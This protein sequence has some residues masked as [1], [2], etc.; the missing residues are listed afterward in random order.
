MDGL[1]SIFGGLGS[2]FNFILNPFILIFVNLLIACYFVFATLNVPSPLG[3]AVIAV[4]IIIRVATYPLV[5]KQLKY[6]KKMQELAP[7]ITNIKNMHKGDAKRIQEETM[8]LHKEHGIN[9]LGGCLPTLIQLPVLFGLYSVLNSVV[10]LAPTAQ[11]AY[12]NSHVLPFLKI[13]QPLD[14]MF[15]G[16]PLG[17]SPSQLMGTL[18]IVIILIPVVTAFFQY[19]QAKMM[20]API[21]GGEKKK[22][23]APDFATTFQSQSAIIFPLLIGFSSFTFPIGLSLYWNAFTIFGIIQQYKIMGLGGMEPIWRKIKK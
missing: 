22:D 14:T 9:P 20:F 19:I 13:S 12:V 15:F 2:V 8:K 17:K 4:T 7:H 1:K 18:G 16:L 6:S 23:A 21:P 10:N 5:A 11:I 3:F